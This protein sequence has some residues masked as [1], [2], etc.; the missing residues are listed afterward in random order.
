[1]DTFIMHIV[2]L[3]F[4]GQNSG[5]LRAIITK[6]SMLPIITE[7]MR[8]A[9]QVIVLIVVEIISVT[10]MLIIIPRTITFSETKKCAEVCHSA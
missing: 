4:G 6:E 1:M 7:K 5:M 9:P 10:M 3:D 8:H 2:H